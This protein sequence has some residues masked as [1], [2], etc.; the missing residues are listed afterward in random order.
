MN[1]KQ[2]ENRGYDAGLM[3][4][5]ATPDKRVVAEGMQGDWMR[6]YRRGC[7]SRTGRDSWPVQPFAVGDDGV[8]RKTF[9]W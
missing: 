5:P 6:G 7:A 3:G 8:A 9:M 2:A 4:M 1:S